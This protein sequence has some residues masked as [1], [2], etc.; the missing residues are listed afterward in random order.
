MTHHCLL[1]WVLLCFQM[2]VFELRG[3]HCQRKEHSVSTTDGFAALC[4][5]S[6]QFWE[7]CSPWVKEHV[8]CQRNTD[9]RSFY[10][11]HFW[12]ETPWDPWFQRKSRQ[13]P[14]GWRVST[15][16][17][18][19]IWIVVCWAS[20]SFFAQWRLL[21]THKAALCR[22]PF[23]SRTKSTLRSERLS[24][25]IWVFV[26]CFT[27]VFASSLTKHGPLHDFC[28]LFRMLLISSWACP[29]NPNRSRALC[30]WK[31][32]Y[33]RAPCSCEISY[34]F[35]YSFMYSFPKISSASSCQILLGPWWMAEAWPMKAAL[36][37]TASPSILRL[38]SLQWPRWTPFQDQI[39]KDQILVASC[40]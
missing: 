22:W 7:D 9:L 37:W 33:T 3:L 11:V 36:M 23:A 32:N 28:L 25:S 40:Y 2:N 26:M 21:S 6:N 16:Q 15:F 12:I 39:D 29:V 10:I 30:G 27:H 14:I 8:Q 34:T 18:T 5:L 4:F 35:R 24:M 31:G 17:Y 38:S 13:R 20:A 19:P 1:P